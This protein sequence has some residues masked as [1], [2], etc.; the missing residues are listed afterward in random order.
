MLTR[1]ICD[2]SRTVFTLNCFN[3]K[4]YALHVP[5]V[6]NDR[7]EL[8]RVA[9]RKL[10]VPFQAL[11]PDSFDFS[12]P[13]PVQKGDMVYR[14]SRGKLL[15][16]FEDYI[17]VPGSVT[18]YRDPSNRKTDPF[19]LGK[20]DIPVPQTIFCASRKR[21]RLMEYAKRLGG[22]PLVLKALGGTR[23]MGVLKIDSFSALASMA[24]FLLNQGKMFVLKKYIPV[25]ASA[26]FIVLGYNVISSLEYIATDR[27]FRTNSSKKLKV[28]PK[29]YSK[30]LENLAV[31]ATH[32]MGWEFGGVDILIHDGKPYVSEVNFPCNFVRAQKIT[33]R[34]IASQMIRYLREKSENS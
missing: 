25:R 34:D 27:D 23:G 26:R 6:E 1:V 21:D 12:K 5:G 20:H 10:K 30:S 11:D 9:C 16:F 24:D 7:L 33:K 4:F 15:R 2:V 18:L 19:L 13:S 28:K 17:A 31:R 32:A 29:K 14:V 8:L 3:M 22:F